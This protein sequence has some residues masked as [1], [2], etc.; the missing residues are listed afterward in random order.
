MF[1]M[2][3]L[4]HPD[5]KRDLNICD[6]ALLA[7]LTLYILAK[8]FGLAFLIEHAYIISWPIKPRHRTVEYVLTSFFVLVPYFISTVLCIV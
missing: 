1:A 6:A 2:T 3:I 4:I 7:C 8:A 5:F